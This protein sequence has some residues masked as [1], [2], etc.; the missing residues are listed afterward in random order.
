MD[1]RLTRENLATY[2]GIP[3]HAAEACQ[4]ALANRK[5][6]HEHLAYN[7][8]LTPVV[9]R[10]LWGNTRPSAAMAKNLVSRTLDKEQRALVIS[11]ENRVGVLKLLI[12]HNVLDRDEQELLVAKGTVGDVLLKQHW[13]DE[14][15][16]KP[17]ALHTGGLSLLEELALSPI[18]RFDDDETRTLLKNHADWTGFLSKPSSTNAR[19]MRILFGRRPA[20]GEGLL[21]AAEPRP[22]M[23]TALA[24]SANLTVEQARKIT[25]FDNGICWLTEAEAENLRFCLMALAANPR[26]SLD[27]VNALGK[28]FPKGHDVSQAATRRYGREAVTGRYADVTEPDVLDWLIGRSCPS[29]SSYGYRQG[30]PIELI[31]LARNPHLSEEQRKRV[32]D[33]VQRDVEPELLALDASDIEGVTIRSNE[34]PT[35]FTRELPDWYRQAT[36]LAATKLGDDVQRW[37]T[38]VGL[39]EDFEGSF[40]ELVE[41]AEAI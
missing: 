22:E 16:R 41:L 5:E 8:D 10:K 7:P 23:L 24:G 27:V 34:Q 4:R 37:E 21:E 17:V 40:T 31:D 14:D 29:N 18:E 36:R 9:W 25:A 2:G 1:F 11:R 12:T 6:M 30:R 3:P 33:G 28:S 15:L 19:L 13:F 35:A 26:C 32:L 20:A 38:L 39:L